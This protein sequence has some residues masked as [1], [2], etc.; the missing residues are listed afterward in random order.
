VGLEENREITETAKARS[1]R[2]QQNFLSWSATFYISFGVS[3]EIWIAFRSDIRFLKEYFH[4]GLYFSKAIPSQAD[5]SSG[6]R[7][8]FNTLTV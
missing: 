4:L 6:T 2:V 1:G 3:I 7:S 5:L 8:T